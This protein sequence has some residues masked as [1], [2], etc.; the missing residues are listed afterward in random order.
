LKSPKSLPVEVIIPIHV[1]LVL[2]LE[3]KKPVCS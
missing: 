1:R 2:L 3:L